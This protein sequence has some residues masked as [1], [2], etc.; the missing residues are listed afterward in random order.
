MFSLA[1]CQLPNL[2]SSDYPVKMFIFV[3]VLQ[4]GDSKQAIEICTEAIELSSRTAHT[5]C[6]RA[7]AYLLEDKFDEGMKNI[8]YCS[9]LSNRYISLCFNSNSSCPV[10]SIHIFISKIYLICIFICSVKGFPGS[11][12]YRSWYAKGK[13]F[14]T[15]YFTLFQQFLLIKCQCKNVFIDSTYKMSTYFLGKRGN[16]KS[17]QTN[18]AIKEERLL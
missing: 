14:F 13:D 7:E 8:Y 17:Q 16:W 1:I 5:F 18:K 6:D 4:T 3:S 2:P 9:I 10:C 12:R 15:F 11:K